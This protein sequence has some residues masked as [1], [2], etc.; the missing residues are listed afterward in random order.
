MSA[1][2]AVSD[3]LGAVRREFAPDPRRELLDV[4]GSL[5]SGRLAWSGR[6]S[7]PRAAD[8]LVSR[9]RALPGVR[10]VQD[11]IVR[12]P[13]PELGADTAALVRVAVAPVHP[14]PRLASGMVSQY[15][16]G[17]RL[18]VLERAGPW[19]RVRGEDAYLGWIH[20]GYLIVGESEW[21]RGWERGE[22][23]EPVVSLGAELWDEVER[24]IGRLPWG[25]RVI[26]ETP[27]R[28]RLP[29]GRFGLLGSGEVVA[30][31]RLADRFP[32]RGESLVRTAR[33][34]Q[35][36]PYLWGGVTPAG[37]DCSGLVQSVY[38]I[39][40]IALP[41]DSDQQASV[42]DAVEPG[43]TFG[44]LRPGDLLFFAEGGDRVTHVAI[45]VGGPG[46]VHSSLSNGCVDTNDLTGDAPLEA[47]LR[48][49]LVG[50]RRV[51]PDV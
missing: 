38:W 50:C 29:D 43:S 18:D 34:W 17:H 39:H 32:P 47:R 16:M 11:G 33:R 27:E 31:D 13:A 26:A 42:G 41:R 6:T 37:C 12:L 40:G 3:L 15:V 19:L 49:I 46:I 5:E 4:E 7:E 25:A 36:A 24:P 1:G 14:E 8:A 48:S 2:D 51:L 44:D 28:I 10:D 9:G 45:S 35:A 20:E 30:V 23:G 22:P 21:A